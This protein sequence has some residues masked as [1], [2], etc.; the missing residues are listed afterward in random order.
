MTH[1]KAL[2]MRAE[3]ADLQRRVRAMEV[4]LQ[5]ES[6]QPVSLTDLRNAY[7]RAPALLAERMPSPRIALLWSKL[8]LR[9]DSKQLLELARSLGEPFPWVPFLRVARMARAEHP[10]NET[11][12]ADEHLTSV[13]R[14]L[15]DAQG[16]S[17]LE[18]ED[19]FA[20]PHALERARDLV[21]GA[22][23]R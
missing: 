11:I 16:L 7:I 3:L 4:L 15:L 12:A 19:M 14:D 5:L 20:T 18:P 6:S 9:I 13:V 22:D 21:H 17:I 1:D 10:S 2:D 8:V 23:S